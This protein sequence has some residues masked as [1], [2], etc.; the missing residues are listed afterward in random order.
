MMAM[1]AIQNVGISIAQGVWSGT[2]ILCSFVWGAAIFGEKIGHLGLSLLGLGILFLGIAGIS[3]SGTKL[4]AGPRRESTSST[5]IQEEDDEE[6]KPRTTR[7]TIFGLVMAAALGIPNG[8]VY[9]PIHYL[10]IPPAS[11]IVCFGL[12]LMICT[13]PVAIAYFLL[14]KKKPVWNWKV[15]PLRASLAGVMWNF[16]NFTSL[17]A[18]DYLGYTVGFPLSQC[19]LLLGGFWG[20]VLFQEITGW[21]R[22]LLYT[23][24]CLVLIGGAAMLGIYGKA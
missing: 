17:Y 22:I 9:A 8:S 3:V 2:T 7:Q 24:S 20:I 6:T 19:A 15:L 14:L 23:F 18:L 5:L 16:G 13:P 12:G 11:Y 21:K 1:V 4:L 10:N